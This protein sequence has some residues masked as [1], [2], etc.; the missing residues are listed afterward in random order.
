MQDIESCLRALTRLIE[1]AGNDHGVPDDVLLELGRLTSA[2]AQWQCIAN[3]GRMLR[4]P[5]HCRWIVS[6]SG[7]HVSLARRPALQ[8]LVSAFIVAR[9]ARPGESLSSADLIAVGWGE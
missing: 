9:C 2:V 1:A 7:A 5:R 8:R 3:W 6:P 4:A